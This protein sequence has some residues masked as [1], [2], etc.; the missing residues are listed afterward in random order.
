MTARR[1]FLAF[2]G[3]VVI[4]G[5]IVVWLNYRRLRAETELQDGDE[6]FLGEQLLRVQ[7]KIS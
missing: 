5:G 6:F 4:I 3:L 2:L 1:V 7:L